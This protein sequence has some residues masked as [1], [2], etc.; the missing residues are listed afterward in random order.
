MKI[1]KSWHIKNKLSKKLSLGQKLQ[2]HVDHAREC[3]CRPIPLP[4]QKIMKERKPKV[5]ASVL[6]K[7]KNKY[8]LV[9]ERLEGGKKWWI[10]PGG[11]VEFGERLEEAAKREIQEETGLAGK[12]KYI[13]HYE[14]VFP[15]FNYHTVIFFYLLETK[16]VKTSR[17]IE[18]KVIRAKWFTKR[19]ISKLRL[20]DS[21]VW[22]FKNYH[23]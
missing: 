16:E 9:E 23:Q 3:G 13:D 6:A 18:G 12:L 21:A 11:K 5:I 14:A 2:W 7:N 22:L 10:V 8:L 4:L 20:V 15:N 19:E 1:N 17:D